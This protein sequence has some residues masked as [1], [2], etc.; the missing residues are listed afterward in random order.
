MQKPTCVKAFV[1]SRSSRKRRSLLAYCSIPS[2]ESIKSAGTVKRGLLALRSC[3]ASSPPPFSLPSF[4]VIFDEILVSSSFTPLNLAHVGS[5]S[6]ARDSY[7]MMRMRMLF[8]R[9]CEEIHNREFYCIAKASETFLAKKWGPFRASQFASNRTRQIR[10][11]TLTNPRWPCSSRYSRCTAT[12]CCIRCHMSDEIH[13]SKAKDHS[14]SAF[15]PS[16]EPCKADSK[17]PER[18]CLNQQALWCDKTHWDASKPHW[19]A[20][21]DGVVHKAS[22]DV[23]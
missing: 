1:A 12:A 22:S 20:L 5:C 14:G 19:I 9:C 10:L 16:S 23:Q 18:I 2:R 17:L 13:T 15:A 6:K 21:D 3:C 11:T 4:P 7:L 8:P